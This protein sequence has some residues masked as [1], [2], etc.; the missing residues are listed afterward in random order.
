M[1]EVLGLQ[2]SSLSMKLAGRTAWSVADLV[3]TADF[4][5]AKPEELMDDVMVNQVEARYKK[6]PEPVGAGASCVQYFVMPWNEGCPRP[7]SNRQPAD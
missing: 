2:P 7:D 1:A 6:A 3:K 4:L 5:Q